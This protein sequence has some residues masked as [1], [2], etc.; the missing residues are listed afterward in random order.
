[1]L[2]FSFLQISE[3]CSLKIN[4]VEQR[5]IR[6]RNS[7]AR[8]IRCGYRN[9]METLLSGCRYTCTDLGIGSERKERTEF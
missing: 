4:L 6:R 5:Q 7:Q 1:M 3:V 8:S 2:F 9:Q